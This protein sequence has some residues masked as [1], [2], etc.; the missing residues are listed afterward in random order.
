M[1]KL[2]KRLFPL[3][4]A[5]L[6][7]VMSLPVFAAKSPTAKKIVQVYY[8]PKSY[9][10]N[11]RNRKPTIEK[12]IDE[13]GKVVPPKYYTVKFANNKKQGTADLIVTA[14]APYTGVLTR[15]YKI[16]KGYPL[17]SYVYN[18]GKQIE[19]LQLSRTAIRSKR[20]YSSYGWSKIGTIGIYRR[21][22]WPLNGDH[23][24]FTKGLFD[25]DPVNPETGKKELKITRIF[26]Y[27]KKGSKK[28]E[29]KKNQGLFVN[30]KHEVFI[31]KKL[32]KDE[33]YFDIY[34]A[35]NTAKDKQNFKDKTL[36]MT[37]VVK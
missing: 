26:V 28:I 8:N 23:S 25:Y 31:K 11:G 24:D 3:L 20:K 1:Q 37:L 10:Y 32:P 22:R 17:A 30:D 5:V 19:V 7:L 27:K 35:G 15:H 2:R 16:E 29:I 6:M 9:V 34:A 21:A 13:D 33:Y 12:V 14:K 4:L 36:H 18:H